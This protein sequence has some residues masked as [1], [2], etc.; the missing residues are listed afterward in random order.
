[1]SLIG[2]VRYLTEMERVYVH[3][4]AEPDKSLLYAPTTAPMVTSTA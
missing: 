1:M 4:L 3:R 2:L